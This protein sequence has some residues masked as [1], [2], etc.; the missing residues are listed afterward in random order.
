MFSLE[1]RDATEPHSGALTMGLSHMA[2]PIS[3][4]RR[5][6][7]KENTPGFEDSR[8]HPG[9]SSSPLSAIVVV[10]ALD[11]GH[12]RAI[13]RTSYKHTWPGG[14][15]QFWSRRLHVRWEEDLRSTE[16]IENR[17]DSCSDEQ[18]MVK[19]EPCVAVPRRCSAGASVTHHLTI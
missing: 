4:M 17:S 8:V 16:C 6:F 11:Y 10:L 12:V 5:L 3:R 9:V 19:E 14:N 15:T 7:V 13:Y 2:E 18:V 1:V